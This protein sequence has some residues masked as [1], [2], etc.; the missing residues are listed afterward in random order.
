MTRFQFKYID[1][2]GKGAAQTKT[3][4]VFNMNDPESSK[5]LMDYIIQSEYGSSQATDD[6]RDMI[7]SMIDEQDRY[8]GIKL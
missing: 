4:P 1:R 3:S 2:S 6:A 5:N 8:N 7:D